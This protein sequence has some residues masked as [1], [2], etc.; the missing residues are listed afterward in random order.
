MA[1]PFFNKETKEFQRTSLENQ[2]R[3]SSDLSSI[4]STI[5]DI[6]GQQ[7]DLL[8]RIEKWMGMSYEMDLEWMQ[9]ELEDK[10]ESKRFRDKMASMQRSSMGTAKPSTDDDSMFDGF[11]DMLTG[12]LSALGLSRMFG[13]K[14]GGKDDGKG[15]GKGGSK[16]KGKGGS[17]KPSGGKGKYGNFFKAGKGIGRLIPGAAIV[18]T[19]IDAIDV[20]MAAFDDDL[21]TNIEGQDLGGLAGSVV[22]GTIGAALGS[23]LGPVGTVVGG[24]VGATLGNIAGSY[25]GDW[26]SPNI[27]REF[28]ESGFKLRQE[29]E[30]L[31]KRL[32]ILTDQRSKGIIDE[33]TYLEERAAI[34]ARL[35]SNE[36]LLQERE[37]AERIYKLRDEAQAKY[38]AVLEEIERTEAEG[39][40][41]TDELLNKLKA[42]EDAFN[43]IDKQLKDEVTK[44]RDFMETAEQKGLIDTGG[45]WSS[46]GRFF[47]AKNVKLDE[48]KLATASETELRGLAE[49][50]DLDFK[51]Q[52]AIENEIKRRSGQQSDDINDPETLMRLFNKGDDTTQMQM[53]NYLR[54][55]VSLQ[56][57]KNLRDGKLT[58][59]DMIPKRSVKDYTQYDDF[60]NKIEPDAGNQR[61]GFTGTGEF[62]GSAEVTSAV[63]SGASVPTVGGLG[64]IDYKSYVG[65]IAEKESSGDY[66]AVNTLGYVGK[67]Q[68]GSMALQD[69]GLVKS[70]TKQS[71]ASMENPDNWTIKGGLEAF[72]NDPALQ[73]KTMAEYTKRNYSTLKRIGVISK[74]SSP[75]E[76]AGY[77]ATSHL[78]G[79]GGAKKFMK[80]EDGADAYGTTGSTYF[81]VGTGSQ[82]GGSVGPSPSGSPSGGNAG[83]RVNSG[84]KLNAAM[85]SGGGQNVVVNNN[86][87]DNSSVS[88][89]SQ[90]TSMPA[91]PNRAR[92]VGTR[93]DYNDP[94]LGF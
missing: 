45:F 80:G 5:Q 68:F 1:L 43:V 82:G 69:A 64:G 39:G 72:L 25:I 65:A 30:E 61:G 35:S 78:L 86:N 89:V 63:V 10:I 48:G 62:G 19:A 49:S 42:A 79:P 41:V 24:A 66:R 3:I 11:G 29:E 54:D 74:N 27:V 51:S 26:I 67:Y 60:G 14:G 34:E 88:S 73:E 44:I 46:V 33:K 57:A 13:G 84:S 9:K 12:A 53:I 36:R 70:G 32:R 7:I 77:L 52:L 87:V 85:S 2:G 37:G 93:L 15:K 18:L 83:S 59:G 50:G 91:T 47:G 75:E 58:R 4:E 21:R 92:S 23:V 40:V 56:A 31:Q 94:I 8:T 38:A 6:G 55:N 71:K 90:T 22:G 20:A 17:G 76:V 28:E 81:A 16:G